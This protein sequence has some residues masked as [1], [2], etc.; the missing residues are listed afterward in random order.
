MEIAKAACCWIICPLCCLMVE[1]LWIRRY[2]TQK[3]AVWSSLGYYPVKNTKDEEVAKG[4]TKIW[5]IACLANPRLWGNPKTA[6]S[7]E[8]LN[9]SYFSKNLAPIYDLRFCHWIHANNISRVTSRVPNITLF[10]FKY[11]FHVLP[12]LFISWAFFFI[13]SSSWAEFTWGQGNALSH[14]S[15]AIPSSCFCTDLSGP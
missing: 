1:G 10:I 11:P 12:L 4:L 15:H 3:R 13:Y 5:T 9:Q 2:W 8:C 7:E 14:G 6:W